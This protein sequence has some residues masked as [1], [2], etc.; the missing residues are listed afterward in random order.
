MKKKVIGIIGGMGSMATLSLFKKF[1]EFSPSNNDRDYPEIIV[2][3]N[4]RVPD[5]TEAL[6]YGGE[7]AFPELLRSATILEN[8]GADY[9]VMACV[10]AHYYIERLQEKLSHAR[11]ISVIDETVECIKKNLVNCNNIGIL[12]STGAIK[13]RLWQDKLANAGINSTILSDRSQHEYFMEAIY[14]EKGLKSGH[15]EGVPKGKILLAIS[16]MMDNGADSIL[17]GCSEIP[18]IVNKKEVPVPFIDCYEELVKG[19]FTKMNIES[20]VIVK[21]LFATKA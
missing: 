7:D 5:R 6:L 2:H 3:N 17:G 19:V 1:I 11:I 16:M 12:A 10:T 15:T 8:S 14:G 21:D 20:T 4:S 13:T 18:M 9:I